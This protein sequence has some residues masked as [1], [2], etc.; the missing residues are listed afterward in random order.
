MARL[1]LTPKPTSRILLASNR[2]PITVKRSEEGEYVFSNGSG[3]LITGLHG[4]SK[5]TTF[6]WYGWP[7]L[8]I[9]DAETAYVS[10][11]LKEKFGVIPVYLNEA[12][13]ELYYNGFSSRKALSHFTIFVDRMA[14]SILWPLVHYHPGEITFT[15]A[16]WEAYKTANRKF[17]QV[18]AKDVEDG[19]LVW[20]HDY[21]LMLLPEMLREEIGPEKYIKIGF[22]LHTPFPSSEIYRILPVRSEILNSV[23]HAD[24][25]GFHTCDYSRH[26]LSACSNILGAS[27]T[28]RTVT[29][30]ERTVGVGAFPI[31]IDPERFRETL[32]TPQVQRRIAELQEEF[33]GKK[34]MVGVDRMDYVKGLPQKLRAFEIFLEEHP[35]FVGKVKFI[36]IAV[37]SR[38]DVEEYQNLRAVVNELV[39]RI[40]G[41]FGTFEKTPIHFMHQ[42]V[43]FPE[44]LALYAISDVCF[45]A[46]T[47]DGM[48]LVSFE[49]IACQ[50]E[51]R[52]T[53]IL[54]EFAGSAK[55]LTGSLIVNPWNVYEMA[56]A[57]YEAYHMEPDERKDRY[58]K[59]DGYVEKFT[60]AFW[61]KTFIDALTK[62]GKDEPVMEDRLW[63]NPKERSIDW[64]SYD[65]Q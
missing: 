43:A 40:N 61:G 36:Q 42:S 38:G 62:V 16:G 23:L 33:E 65:G 50:R 13:A 18:L 19:D 52:G 27:T 5:A 21:H 53:L 64:R 51:R 2:L 58:E 22:F 7:G 41:R 11:R 10:A 56:R 31:G 57:I 45:V 15:E 25:I 1:L 46:S 44:L 63:M 6:Q 12:L 8:E 29:Y 4:L 24:L 39:G 37:P 20:I 17:A 34:V 9:P 60:S 30:N 26:F 28:T 54:S 14:D 47:R 59:M 35:E 55:S 3:G 32:A 49:Y 48:N